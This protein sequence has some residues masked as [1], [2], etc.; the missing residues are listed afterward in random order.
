VT[1]HVRL[2]EERG[3]VA[4]AGILLAMVMV[5]LIGTAV[6]IGRAFIVRRDLTAMADDA[7]LAGSQQL[8][9]NAWRQGTLALDPQA[10]Q[11]TAE[12]QLAADPGV[13]GSATAEPSE[14]TVQAK[15]QFPTI[16][17]R[18]VGMNELT[19]SATATAVPRQ[20]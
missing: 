17:L 10:A 12:A 18:L 9:V 8:D 15:E 1:I 2:R 5:M 20:P 6:D 3:S 11:Q 14:I 7:A 19:V 16:V 13:S 4:I